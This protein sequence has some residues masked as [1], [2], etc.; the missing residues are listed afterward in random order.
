MDLIICLSIIKL[1]YKN[2]L[3]VNIACK[4]LKTAR[5]F[6]NEAKKYN[7]NFFIVTDGASMINNNGNQAVENAR[8]CQI[9]WEKKHNFDPNEDW[10]NKFNY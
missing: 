4:Y 6:L 3:D 8:K 2:I 1:L 9:E 7:A 10:S 5:E